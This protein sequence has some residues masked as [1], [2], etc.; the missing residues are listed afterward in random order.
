MTINERIGTLIKALNL[1][2]N[3][4]SQRIGVN[5]TIIHNIVKGRNA[6][7]FDIL[8]KIKL[9]FDN[10]NTDWLITGIGT[11]FNNQ[12]LSDNKL[13]ETLPVKDK[14]V[15]QL[16]LEKEK[17]IN[18]L[19]SHIDTL[20]RELHRCQSKLDDYENEAP[21]GQKRKVG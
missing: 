8:S 12:Q 10:I 18:S 5:P 15:C 20:Q 3:S 4:F 19:Q 7:S 14:A 17:L 2:N 11:I 6:P 16:C 13:T 1:N 9:S 21:P